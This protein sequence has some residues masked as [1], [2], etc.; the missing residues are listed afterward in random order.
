MTFFT[1]ALHRKTLAADAV[2]SIGLVLLTYLLH[3]DALSANW[4][5]D[6]GWLL[7]FATRY[8]P[9]QYFFDP[10]ITRAY[11]PSNVTPFNPFVFDINLH[12]FGLQPQWFYFH[13]LL[14]IAL[15]AIGLYF[16]CKKR[17][18]LGA[19][20]FASSLF[21]V[22]APVAQMAQQLMVGHYVY[23]LFFSILATGS[24][25]LAL[26]RRKPGFALYGGLFYLLAVACKE[27][28]VP[29]PL[30]LLFVPLC[31][32]APRMFYLAPYLLVGIVYV[33]WR[34]MVL[35]QFVGG[36]SRGEFDVA[37]AI[38]QISQVPAW[39]LGGGV[40][41][42][43]VTLALAIGVGWV[44]LG[45]R[46]YLALF[47][48]TMLAVL[49]PMVALTQS[50][51]LHGPD[52]YLFVPWVVLVVFSAFLLTHVGRRMKGVAS[53]GAVALW[54]LA[55]SHGYAQLLEQ[56]PGLAEFD[57]I[58][59]EALA[60]PP[61]TLLF[62]DGMPLRYLQVVLNG[63]RRAEAVVHNKAFDEV[64]IVT[65]K[66]NW[67]YRYPRYAAYRYFE[68][69]CRCFVD[70]GG[71]LDALP[72]LD[73][74]MAKTSFEHLPF[75]PPPYPALVG[76]GGGVVDSVEVRENRLIIIGWLALD[77]YEPEH[78]L[79]LIGPRR[80]V[81]VAIERVARPDVARHFPERSL[82][83]AGF[84][85]VLR[86]GDPEEAA[87]A[88]QSPCLVSMSSLTGLRLLSNRSAPV[89]TS[90]ATIDQSP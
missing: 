26:E 75:G 78:S 35:G 21:L 84:R 34:Q 42:S 90:L 1:S 87:I 36:Y 57:A 23:G 4:R 73:V 56:R 86:Y 20:V 70:S 40:P 66:A 50:P 8:A 64:G 81:A 71:N 3:G 43:L 33:V 85:L 63:S 77:D 14:I 29:L 72:P 69:E 27:V 37:K 32:F 82:L 9:D 83:N 49:A 18:G 51:G 10:L 46:E 59:R 15:C 53:G 47:V 13:H 88:Q 89:C 52:R 67:G 5:F 39:L 79:V 7:D 17:L 28:F 11:S 44:V 31:R 2:V 76:S 48:V 22:G 58:Y 19:A 61:K 16:V 65:R 25:L 45:K 30:I 74:G 6:D 80:P 68:R 41:G 60:A 54:L 55:A 12:L 62:I 24:F 38:E